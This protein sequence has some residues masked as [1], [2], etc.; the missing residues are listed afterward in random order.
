MLLNSSLHPLRTCILLFLVSCS[1]R[2]AI[3][4]H[5]SSSCFQTLGFWWC[6]LGRHR[7]RRRWRRL[8]C[9][10]SESM[11]FEAKHGRVGG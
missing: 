10:K 9:W 8:L 4:S 3:S 7:Q 11:F 2:S 1:R 5:L 6:G